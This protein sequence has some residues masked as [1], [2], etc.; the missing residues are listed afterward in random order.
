MD[1]RVAG[2]G[3]QAAAAEGGLVALQV[4]HLCMADNSSGSGLR[5]RNA[6]V[7]FQAHAAELDS[8]GE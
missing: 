6:D 5:Q 8:A 1:A 7:D 3:R 2:Q 4:D